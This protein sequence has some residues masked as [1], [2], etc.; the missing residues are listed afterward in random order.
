MI[1]LSTI[2]WLVILG[3]WWL[4]SQSQVTGE[5]ST[6]FQKP[7]RLQAQQKDIDT[8]ELW[9]HSGPAVADVDGDGLRD[10]V[11]GDYSGKFHFFRNIGSNRDPKYAAPKYLMA[12]DVEAQVN[13]YCCIGSSPH[14]VDLDGDGDLDM[15]SGSYD[16]GEC[17]LFRGLGGAKFAERETI[18]DKSGKAVVRVPDQ[19]GPIQSFGSWPTTVDWD[20]DGKPDLLVGAFGGE[21]FVRLNVGSRQKPEF[22]ATNLMVQAG[23]KELQVP[24]GHATP[25]VTDWDDDGRWDILSGSDSGAVYFYQNVGEPG[26]PRFEEARVLIGPHEGRGTDKLV[27]IDAEPTPGIRSQIAAVDYNGDGKVDLL[28]GDFRTTISPRPELTPT[29]RAA[30][31]TILKQLR[32][33][34]QHSPPEVDKAC[35]EMEE[36]M[37]RRFPGEERYSEKG[38]AAY[39]IAYKKLHESKEFKQ[40]RAGTEKLNESLTKYLVKPE[41]EGSINKYATC[42]GYVWLFLRK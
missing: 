7:I 34:E 35:E 19:K 6:I 41:R 21:M 40:W 33:G 30:I 17:Y 39:K 20:H 9:G 26:A 12:G 3:N 42:H 18:V 37:A 22:A 32:D 27:E 14:F 31:Q 28:V 10:L 4:V 5:E 8:G 29:D 23:G 1:R 24:D 25:V 11:V 38:M 16:P 13:I 15:I 36:D 2:C